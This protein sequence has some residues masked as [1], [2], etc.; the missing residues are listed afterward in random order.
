MYEDGDP[1]LSWNP[2]TDNVGVIDYLVYQNGVLIATVATSNH[3][4]TGL[5]QK[6]DH[7]FYVVA[8]DLSGNK[9]EPSEPVE[10]EAADFDT[11][12]DLVFVSEDAF[13]NDPAEWADNDGDGIGN[14]S[15]ND[16]DNDNIEDSS[17]NCPLVNNSNQLDTDRDLDGDVCDRDDDNDG[18]LDIFDAYP[19]ISL[20]GLADT[21]EDGIPDNCDSI[22]I[23]RGL[24][25]DDDDDN[26]G[27]QDLQ[28]A[29]PLI[30]LGDRRDTDS[31]GYQ[32]SVI[33]FVCWQA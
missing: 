26:D 6:L 12:G 13:P 10:I 30:S 5:D 27:L 29:F 9:S 19:L 22:C 17:D 2:S 3:S 7:S 25:A 4:L 20:G 24:I 23:G 32:M 15:D 21:D 18:I 1:K 28:D 31:D 33:R 11:D 16:D 14:N 8:R